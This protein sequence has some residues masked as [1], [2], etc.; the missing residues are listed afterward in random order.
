MSGTVAERARNVNQP[1]P[2][3]P[4]AADKSATILKVRF[5]AGELIKTVL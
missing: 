3:S 5:V 2:I 1:Q 4:T